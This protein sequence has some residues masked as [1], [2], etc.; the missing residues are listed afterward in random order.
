M[1]LIDKKENNKLNLSFFAIFQI[2]FGILLLIYTAPLFSEAFSK[3]TTIGNSLN[4]S[5]HVLD[6]LEI[7]D[8][9]LLFNELIYSIITLGFFGLAIF[10]LVNG[11]FELTKNNP[12][13]IKL[14]EQSMQ[15]LLFVLGILIFTYFLPLT[16]SILKNF[17]ALQ[18]ATVYYW[19]ILVPG[20]II[21]EAIGITL[22]IKGITDFIQKIKSLNP[23]T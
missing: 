17:K 2:C 19:P 1:N 11:V 21:I 8:I 15:I 3:T 16:E 20:I 23:K 9:L 18:I 10:S 6:E 5:V 14:K 12:K 22:I 7:I 4:S 13:S